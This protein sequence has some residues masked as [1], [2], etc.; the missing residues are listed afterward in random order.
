VLD[1]TPN[2][3]SINNYLLCNEDEYRQKVVAENYKELKEANFDLNVDQLNSYEQLFDE[4]ISQLKEIEIDIR[5]NCK[6]NTQN[7]DELASEN[8]EILKLFENYLS[9][10]FQ[11]ILNS[12]QLN[13]YKREEFVQNPRFYLK[14]KLN[15][16]NIKQNKK[17]I[18]DND[19]ENVISKVESNYEILKTHF[20]CLKSEYREK[21]VSIASKL[22]DCCVVN[23]K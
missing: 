4:K 10:E 12:D 2:E 15:K 7:L 6:L 16:Y 1:E 11:K 22:E 19:I 8:L 9:S 21:C 18:A 3:S 13:D 14:S 23:T 17:L 5:K 20:D